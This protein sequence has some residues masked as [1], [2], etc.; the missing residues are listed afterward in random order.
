MLFLGLLLGWST[1]ASEKENRTFPGNNNPLLSFLYPY[2]RKELSCWRAGAVAQLSRA[3]VGL[4]ADT[5]RLLLAQLSAAAL[6]WAP[7]HSHTAPW[8]LHRSWHES[9]WLWGQAGWAHICLH[10][11]VLTEL[12]MGAEKETGANLQECLWIRLTLAATALQ[13][14]GAGVQPELLGWILLWKR[15]GEALEPAASTLPAGTQQEQQLLQSFCSSPSSHFFPKCQYK[16][17]NTK[18]QRRD[19]VFCWMPATPRNGKHS[20]IFDSWRG[21]GDNIGRGGE[22]Y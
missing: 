2:L 15:Q 6:A 19:T 9:A 21:D 18:Y 20:G 10:L 17:N 16:S 11:S 12:K 22:Q 1:A 13:E 3:A 5:Q 4:C 7:S 14:R 8:L